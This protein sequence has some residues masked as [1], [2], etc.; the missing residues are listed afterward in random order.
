MF[1]VGMLCM[2]LYYTFTTGMQD[3]KKMMPITFLWLLFVAKEFTDLWR[4]EDK[5]SEKVF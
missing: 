5:K 1:G 2:V 3:Y 4:K